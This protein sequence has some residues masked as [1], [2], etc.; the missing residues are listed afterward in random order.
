MEIPLK[1]ILQ[2][3][4]LFINHLLRLKLGAQEKRSSIKGTKLQMLQ[5]KEAS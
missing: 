5:I 3:I 4:S 1:V 2:L